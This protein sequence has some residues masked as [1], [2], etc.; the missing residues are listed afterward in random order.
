MSVIQPISSLKENMDYNLNNILQKVSV[1]L[2][3]YLE[4]ILPSLFDDWWTQAVIN[5]LSFQQQQ[6]IEQ[7]HISSLSGLDLA[8]LLRL[9][10]QNWYQISTKLNLPSEARH[11]V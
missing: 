5:N 1:S 10:D 6:R 8:A 7:R 11:F 4:K 3:A 2:A 9:F